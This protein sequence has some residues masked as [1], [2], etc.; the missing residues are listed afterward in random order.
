MYF[1]TSELVENLTEFV[2]Y[3]TVEQHKHCPGSKVIWY[4]S[5]IETGELSWQNALNS[6]NR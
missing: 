3:L 2:K 1:Q 5:V 6:K 4:D